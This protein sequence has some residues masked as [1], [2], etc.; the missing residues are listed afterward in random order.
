MKITLKFDITFSKIHLNVSI[1]LVNIKIKAAN[2][3]KN[4]IQISILLNF[5]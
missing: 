2:S 4:I 5:F 3:V 1:Q